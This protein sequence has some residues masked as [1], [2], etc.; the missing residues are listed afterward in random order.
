MSKCFF[1]VY[2]IGD[3]IALP[4]PALACFKCK[5][6]K[7][8]E[9]LKGEFIG[10]VT[11]NAIMYDKFYIKGDLTCEKCEN[12]LNEGLH[13]CPESPNVTQEFKRLGERI[14]K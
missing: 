7:T 1:K 5:T 13:V 8:V 2:K 9:N 14:R 6:Q 4:F 11:I 3:V 12:L 10:H